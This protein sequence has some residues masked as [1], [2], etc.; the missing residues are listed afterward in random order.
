MPDQGAASKVEPA[1]QSVSPPES[2]RSANNDTEQA[3]NAVAEPEWST[4]PSSIAPEWTLP[5]ATPPEEVT[6]ATGAEK[7]KDESWS[8]PDAPFPDTNAEP[9]ENWGKTESAEPAEL[10]GAP[11][12]TQS[13]PEL[14]AETDN[15]VELWAKPDVGEAAPGW[16]PCPDIFRC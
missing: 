11:T 15:K 12:D 4:P 2:N 5:G 6:W 7:S 8:D 13:P 10:W 14:W 16:G 9:I 1:A 3:K